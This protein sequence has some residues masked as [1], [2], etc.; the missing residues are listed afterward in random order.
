MDN[1]QISK[2]DDLTLDLYFDLAVLNSAIKIV[3]I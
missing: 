2:L 3:K 1:K